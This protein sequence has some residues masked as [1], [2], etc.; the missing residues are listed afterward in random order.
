MLAV[1]F[2]A[3]SVSPLLADERIRIVAANLTSGNGQDYDPGHGNRIL[4]GLRPDIVLVQEFNYLG[5]TSADFRAWVDMNFGASFSYVREP[6]PS[7]I[8]NGV[9]SRYP[10]LASGAWTDAN[11]S[12][13][14]FVW[15]RIDI[16]GD[17]D[18]WAI[19]VHLLTTSA[20]NRNAE[21]S[22]ILNYIA[23]QGIPATD[24]VTLGGDFNT[25]NRS[26]SCLSTLSS[27]FSTSGPW[28][29]DQSGNGNT[30]AGRNKPYDWVLADAD[31]HA[32]RTPLVLGS[33]SFPN[34][35]VFDSRVYSPLP[36]PVLAGDSGATNMQHMAVVRDFLIPST[37]TPAVPSIYSS[38]TASATTG[39]GFTYQ[40]AATQSP[41]SFGASGLPTG[42][43]VNSATGLISGTPTTAGSAS[44]T[45]SATNASGTGTATLALT[46][47]APGGGSGNGA[48]LLDENFAAITTGDNTSTGG[49]SSAWNG[50]AASFPTV[51]RAFQA[52][53]AV[54][55][56]SGSGT[57]SLT[58]KT[59]DLSAGGGAFNVSFKVKGWTAV[60]GDIIVSVT[61]LA[62]QTVT[63]TAN[64]GAAF[65]TKTLG[66]TG[67]MANSTLTIATTA[68]RAFI[69]D[70]LVSVATA[71]PT[72]SAV[73]PLAAV[74][75]VYG[76]A[77]PTPASLSISGA[78]L[79][80]G[81]L[82][83]AP[84]G[85]EV[86]QS[87]GGTTGYAATQTLAATSG[88]VA[89]T[90]VYL[91]L[92]ASTGAGSYVGNVVCSSAGAA[93]AS[94]PVAP[95]AVARR[96]LLITA[97]DRTKAFGTAFVTGTSAFTASGLVPGQT[98]GSVTLTA[99]GGTATYDAAGAYAIV[100]SNAAGGTFLAANYSISY[101]QG[102]LS[103]TAPAFAEWAEGLSDPAPTADPDGDG[104]V[105]LLEYYFGLDAEVRDGASPVLQAAAD[106]AELTFDY[107]RNKAAVGVTGTVESTT[108]LSGDPIWST[109][110]ALSDV[111]LTDF[112]L[113]ETRRATVAVNPGETKK[114]VR[115]RVTQ[116]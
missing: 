16:P 13:R 1:A 29:V 98:I 41:T 40:I 114:F 78:G 77:S 3:A 89:P 90:T 99:V 49:S 33:N 25:D 14:K 4:Q 100:A 64:I 9:V 28:P 30:N 12:N 53:G 35:L 34:G 15:A 55:L 103:V 51:V 94:V 84:A 88:T 21:A 59:L 62:S 97:Q 73:G 74:D 106:G 39:Q 8:P 69:D 60:E 105:N 43:G 110:D 44:V 52:G 95:S 61:G 36:S 111:L 101:E 93:D 113:Y 5:N 19:S 38:A 46:V 27:Y 91:R 116:P 112:E 6:N 37:S 80:A 2:A 107:R 17:K 92:A 32:R 24:Y 87:P 48:V 86:S 58:S 47:T 10:I 56:G 11:V 82:V 85:F 23:A 81:I 96:P 68:G 66:F 115:L 65:E 108:E 50:S 22:Q 109:A 71:T 102:T 63:Y 72:L 76:T 67:A 104:V 54:R 57:G 26:E 45:L 83:T 42:L 7:Q 70:V 79:T 31:L 75:T 18:L 20:S